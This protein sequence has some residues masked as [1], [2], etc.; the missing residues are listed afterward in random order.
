MQRTAAKAE[1]AI[2]SLS[3]ARAAARHLNAF[4]NYASEDSLLNSLKQRNAE[5]GVLS[6]ALV[7]VKDN[8][9]TFDLPTT[10]ASNIL[11]RYMS[12]HDATVVRHIREAGGLIVG[13]T[14]MDEFGMG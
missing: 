10:C 13:K 6:G 3:S 8:I 7:A 12:P 5:G 11:R 1:E 14:N 9:C 4:T 2:R